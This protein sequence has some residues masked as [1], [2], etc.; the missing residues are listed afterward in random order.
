MQS[1][2]LLHLDA[3]GARFAENEVGSLSFT[4]GREEVQRAASGT[5]A[6][7]LTHLSLIRTTGEDAA[8]LLQNLLS[9][10]VRKL[11]PHHA[12]RSS[13]N[14]PKGRM[15][16]SFILWREA[17]DFILQA[18]ADLAPATI[19]KLSMYVLRSKAK[20]SGADAELAAIGLAGPAVARVLDQLGLQL[21]PEP[22]QTS[23]EQIRVVRLEGPR[24]ML[25]TAP[26]NCPELWN[27]ITAAG[28]QPAGTAA[29][30]WLD[31]QQGVP[32]ITSATQD[33]FVAQMLNFEL[34][35]GVSF[36]KGCYP[37][38]EII[39]RMQ[40]LGKLKKRMFRAHSAGEPP[41]V[42]AD[43]YSAGFGEQS[44]GKV[45]M[46]APAPEQGCDLLVV[47]QTASREQNDVRL[48]SLEGERLRFE[49]LPYPVG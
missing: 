14:S 46:A 43:L 47:V 34:I 11:Q 23:G 33:E 39:A 20:I 49:S 16:A 4:E 13:L 19:R 3:A 6:V 41:Q 37:G 42:G 1:P 21:P 40:Y 10:D 45:V 9:N 36:Q 27:K 32:L 38:Q 24:V 18:S 35:G 28:V 15:L 30:R 2:W 44:V 7:P 29:W 22:L 48:G 12:Q 31:I 17:G 8:S 26:A 5:I 25:L